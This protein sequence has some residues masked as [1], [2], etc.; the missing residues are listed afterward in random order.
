M[1]NSKQME[2]FP[3]SLPEDSPA[4]TSQGPSSTT[5]PESSNR[6]QGSGKSTQDSSTKSNP[7][8][9]S[10]KTSPCSESEDWLSF[11]ATFGRSG[12]TRSGIAYPLPPLAR[13]TRGTGSGSRRWPTPTSRDWKDGSA[14]SC[15]NVPANCLLGREVHARENYQTT[16][17]L[18]PTFCE[19]LLGYPIGWTDL[20][21]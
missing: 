18:N 12:I 13:L 3:M 19:W 2:L 5:P 1:K 14:Q 11:S 16:G 9:A 6:D 10:L 15:R 7:S 4:L 20:N 8:G 17:S 21:S